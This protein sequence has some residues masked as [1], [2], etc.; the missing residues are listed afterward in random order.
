MNESFWLQLPEGG[1]R[2]IYKDKGEAAN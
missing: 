2:L 1:F